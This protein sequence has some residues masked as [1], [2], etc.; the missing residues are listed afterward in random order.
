M[1]ESTPIQ[2]YL[3]PD[4]IVLLKR[5]GEHYGLD[6]TGRPGAKSRYGVSVSDTYRLAMRVTDWLIELGVR[7]PEKVI[8]DGQ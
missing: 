6:G 5:V 2:I 1:N 8:A 4:E 3:T 7:P